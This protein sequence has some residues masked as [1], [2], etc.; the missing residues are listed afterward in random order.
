MM[1]TLVKP[2]FDDL[3]FR[4]VSSWGK[5]FGKTCNETIDK[6]MPGCYNALVID[7]VTR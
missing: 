7:E 5:N 1:L 6:F 3:W 2:A 4:G